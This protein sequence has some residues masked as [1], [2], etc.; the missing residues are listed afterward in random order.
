M[1]RSQ[2]GKTLYVIPGL[3]MFPNVQYVGRGS[4]G[5]VYRG[6][7]KK[8]HEYAIKALKTSGVRL[9]KGLLEN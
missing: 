3:D 4:F 5:T 2:S 6:M 9:N 8:G 1:N 7:D